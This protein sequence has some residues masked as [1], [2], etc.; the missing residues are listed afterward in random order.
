M[1]YK[2]GVHVYEQPTSIIPPVRVDASMP[3]VFGVAPIHHLDEDGPVNTPILCYSYN[4]AVTQLGYSDDFETWNLCE[5]MYSMFA[6]FSV[7]PVVF[8]NVFDPATHKTSAEAEA[9]TLDGDSAAVAHPGILADTLVVKNKAG[10]TTHVADTDY[11]VDR[12]SGTITRLSGGD[13][14]ANAELTVDYDYGDPSKVT[15]ADIIGGIDAG[16]GKAEGLELVNSI[17]PMFGMVPGQLLSPGYSIDSAVAAVMHA[18]AGNIN[19]HFKA[20]AVVDIDSDTVTKYDEVSAK[21]NTDNL[22]DEQLVVCWPKVSLGGVEYWMSSQVAA[23]MC[24]VDADNEGIP[25]ASPSNH[26]LQ[27]DSAVANGEPVWLGPDQATYLNSQGIVTAL[28]FIGG[29]K[30]WGNR[31]GCYPGV[32]DVKDAYLPIRRMFNW[33]GNVLVQ[34]YWQKVDFPINRRLIE[35]IVDSVNI[36]LNGLAARQ[37]ILGGRVEFQDDENATTDLIDGIIKFH[38]YVTPP[39]PAREIDFILEYDPEYTSTLFG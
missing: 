33:I 12:A 14:D 17:F 7:S 31:T 3:V 11:I 34:T 36:W 19:G 6:L 23:L 38:V 18:K 1:S 25:Y 8:V 35:T 5:F 37:F 24:Q 16:T 27:M 29:W 22:T 32:T 2:H 39:A 30:C 20:I 13:I 28:N 15:T 21:K 10:D 4:G 26:S 9:L